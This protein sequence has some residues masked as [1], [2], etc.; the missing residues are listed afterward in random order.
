[1][2]ATTDTYT[3]T[4]S[5]DGGPETL[6]ATALYQA[7]GLYETDSIIPTIAGI[8]T[9]TAHM[10]N[11][12]TAQDSSVL[13]ELSN[14]PVTSIEVKPGLIDPSQCTTTVLPP[15][16][17]YHDAGTSFTFSIQIVD[18]WGN[19]FDETPPQISAGMVVDARAIYDNHNEWVSPIGVS[20]DP[21]A[22]DLVATV[23]DGVDGT[24]NASV[25]INRAG[26]YELSI[27]VD[28]T[29]VFSSPQNVQPIA[30]NAPDCVAIDT[31]LEMF[32]GFDYSFQI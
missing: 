27:T 26:A 1:M 15:T 16:I 8:Y 32:A 31:P 18:E 10:T 14:S 17:P 11:A 3:V 19:L 6:S 13:I 7:N 30:L 22:T 29:E 4:L 2:D 28:G 24:M 20:D 23:T 25:T 5:R 12:Y 9:L 21:Y